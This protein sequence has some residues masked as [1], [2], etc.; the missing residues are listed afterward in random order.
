[1]SN[2]KLVKPAHP[3]H[4]P[5]KSSPARTLING[6]LVKPEQSAHAEINSVEFS[7]VSAVKVV[8]FVSPSHIL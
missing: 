1:M 4:A 6:K 2:G 8:I 7:R 5:P 3:S